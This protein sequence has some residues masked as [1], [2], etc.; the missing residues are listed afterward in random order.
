MARPRKSTASQGAPAVPRVQAVRNAVRILDTV[1][2]SG[3]RGI[4]LG[5]LARAVELPK[6]TVLRIAT[7][8]MDEGLIQ[9]EEPTGIYRL[10]IRTFELGS[11]MI[12]SLEI[13][14]QARPYLERLADETQETVHL[15]VLDEGQV[16][17]VDKI[18]SPQ[19]LRLYS[20][21]GRRA[22]AHCTAVGKALL[23][24]LPA[25][26]RHRVVE[27]HPLTAYTPNTI[28]D[29]FQLEKELEE[30][31]RTGVAFDREEHE[32]GVRCAAAPI[33]DYTG[34][35]RAAVSVT[36]PTFRANSERMKELAG[37]VRATAR[38]ISESLG[39]RTHPRAHGEQG[40]G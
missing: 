2:Q 13:P 5:E 27:E 36:A 16:V 26:E 10:G 40:S 32:E 30:I 29:F 4:T 37:A 28:T 1:G 25:A 20:R 35:V 11:L 22:P 7:T 38:A 17:Y 31:R 6:T 15:G 3:A 33:F 9:R 39:Y 21:I 23:A 24:H 18:E 12:N 14:R 19:I 34:A 8:L